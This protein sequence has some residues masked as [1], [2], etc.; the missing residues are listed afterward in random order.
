MSIPRIAVVGV[1][2][3]AAQHR[4]MAT[5]LA[6]RGLVEYA[7]QVAIPYDQEHL[8]DEV[9]AIRKRG[10]D[11]YPS[12]RE[13]LASCRD[14]VDLVTIPTGIPLHRTMAVAALEA[15]CHVLVE[16]PAA[17]SIQDVD[18]M[19]ATQKRVGRH[20]LVGY[21][22]VYQPLGQA[23]KK[24]IC[25][26]RF[27]RVRSLRAFGC[28]PRSPSYYGRNG[29]AGRL[30]VGDTWVLDGPHNNAMAHSVNLMCFLGSSEPGR[31]L[32]PTAVQAE[33]H[34]ANEIE[35]ADTVAMRVNTAE[36]VDVFFT[37]S[38]C[39]DQSID[40][41]FVLESEQAAVTF[42]YEGNAVIAWS[43]GQRET[44]R[45]EADRLAVL[46]GAVDL[47][48]GN[49]DAAHCPLE[50]ARSQ[51]LCACGSFESSPIHDLP[52]DLASTGDEETVI[53]RG[54]TESIQ[55]AF[56]QGALF[57]EL[58]IPWSQASEVFSLE[59]YA[60]FPTNRRQGASHGR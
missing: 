1:G 34:R 2:G 16:K 11:V 45:F 25:E 28:W 12:L 55:E 53:V 3:F 6:D 21:Q 22:H 29:W 39:T 9:E 5:A 43:D 36:G 17:G 32:T 47:L 33:L 18:A 27:G 51:T 23:V 56:Q 10:V 8:R 26:G 19:L 40:P 41:S 60:Y 42:D 15:G 50:M 24:W 30:A 59:E 58:G 20:C 14:R 57:S 44:E 46:E 48:T 54:M 52:P 4:H 37:A 31:S 35:S 38:H 13:L 49:P 7:A